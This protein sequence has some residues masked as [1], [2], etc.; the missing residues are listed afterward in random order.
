M[1]NACRN[2]PLHWKCVLFY[3][4]INWHKLPSQQVT[5]SKFAYFIWMQPNMSK[6]PNRESLQLAMCC[7]E[8]WLWFVCTQCSIAGGSSFPGGQGCESVCNWSSW[9]SK[10]LFSLHTVF[11]L[12]LLCCELGLLPGRRQGGLQDESSAGCCESSLA[13]G[14]VHTRAFY[15]CSV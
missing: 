8:K 6:F 14:T 10:C 1:L 9:G 12:L 4:S 5:L 15:G 13:K 7:R 11:C 2:N 3:H